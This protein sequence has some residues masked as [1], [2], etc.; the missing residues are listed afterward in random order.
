[1]ATPWRNIPITLADSCAKH[2]RYLLDRIGLAGAHD[3]DEMIGELGVHF[4]HVV[5]GH[6]TVGAV[7]VGFGTNGRRGVGPVV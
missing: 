2:L 3:A 4:G 6:V 7:G 5:L 1:M